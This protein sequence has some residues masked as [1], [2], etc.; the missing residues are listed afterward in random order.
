MENELQR[1]EEKKKQYLALSENKKYR[2][3]EQVWHRLHG[4]TYIGD[5]V[6][7]ASDGIVTTFAV[8]AGVVGA[9]LAPGIVIILGLAN[10]FADGFSM[11]AS[12]L[13]SLRAKKEFANFQRKKEE[14]EVEN[15][16]EIEREEV[17]N[18]MK[19]W[20]V[21]GDLVEGA[22]NAITRDKKKWVDLMMKEELDFE[23]EPDAS[24]MSHGIATFLA[25][26]VAGSIPLIPYLFPFVPSSFQFIVSAI[27]AGFTFFAV[28][29][30]RSL[31]TTESSFK[32]GFEV[33]LVG[34]LAS[35]VAFGLGWTIKTTFGIIL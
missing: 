31:I 17:R 23:E 6:Y 29:A 10:L 15:F 19:H 20:G 8:V 13:L 11:G 33:L 30:A 3:A 24:P 35:L 34:G 26:V 22:T 16:P 5:L 7:G 18:I 2:E 32:A 14:W 28:G 21:P 4:G 9:S 1:E 25:F 27:L 12:N